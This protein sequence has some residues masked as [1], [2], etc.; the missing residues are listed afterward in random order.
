MIDIPFHD[1][2]TEIKSRL[3]FTSLSKLLQYEG[4]QNLKYHDIW[5]IESNIGSIM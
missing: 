5:S 4:V 3:S 2:S 1:N